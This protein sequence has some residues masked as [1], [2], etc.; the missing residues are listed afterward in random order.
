M[1]YFPLEKARPAQVTALEFIQNAVIKGYHDIVI[2][3]PTGCHAADEQVLMADGSLRAVQNV[4]VGDALLGPDSQPR[5]VLSLCRGKDEMFAV[6]PVKGEPF[7]VNQHHVL[8]LQRTNDGWGKAYSF[9]DIDLK[10]YTAQSH[11]FKHLHKLCKPS[12]VDF[13]AK[14]L[15]IP[16]Y[17]LG[18]WL[19]DGDSAGVALTS[20][21]APIQKEWL[22]FG[23]S[24]Y[25][26]PC[27]RE[28]NGCQHIHL[29][30]GKGGNDRVNG[31]L[32]ILRYYNLVLNKHIPF[33]YLTSSLEDRFQLLAGLLDTD[34][35]LANGCFDFVSTRKILSEQTAYIARSLGFCAT[36]R[37]CVKFCQT[38]NSSQAWR[39][40]ISGYTEAIPTRIHR[41][42]AKPRQQIKSV[43]R[44]GFTLVR[45]GIA[46]YYG[47]QV[48]A[49]H[50]YL[51][52]DFTV[53]HN[54]GKSAIGAAA[55][56]WAG[57]FEI[58]GHSP[59]GYYLVTQ[60][61]LQDQL[62]HDFPRWKP[63]LRTNGGSLKS[64]SEYPCDHYITC[65]A[66]GMASQ[67]KKG[68]K[69]SQRLDKS[70]PYL[71]A[72]ARF[73]L[74]DVAVTNYPYLFTEHLYVGEM[75]PRNF[76]VLDECHT[77]ERQITGFIEILVNKESLDA[78][79]PGCR[80]VPMMQHSEDLVDWL[81]DKYL[82]MCKERLDMLTENLVECHYSNR[83][84]QN[85]FNQ[86]KNHV[87]RIS[88]AMND[89]EKN[90]DDWVFWQEK[91]DSEWACMA[92][93]LSA[94]PFRPMLLND[95]GAIRL[96][97]S[98]YPGPKDVFC[99]SLGLNPKETAWLELDSTFPIENRLIHMTT[100][101]SM[102]RRF[103]EETTPHL[104][105]MCETILEAHPDEKGLIHSH[106]YQ[107]GIK[108]Y[109]YL[110]SRPVGKRV[111][112][113]TKASERAVL[114][115]R[116]RTS[117]YPT[118]MLSPS[119]A[120]GFSFDDDLARFQIIAKVPYPY[121]GD[122]Q[123]AAKMKLDQDWY[124][125]Q[126]VMTVLQTCGRI[127][128]CLDYET[129]ILTTE[130]WKGHSEL[131]PGDCTYGINPQAFSKK[132][133]P[134]RWNRVPLLLNPVLGVTF[135]GEQPTV[136][137]KAKGVDTVVTEGHTIVYQPVIVRSYA[138]TKRYKIRSAGLSKA[139][140]SELPARFKLPLAGYVNGKTIRR[141]SK[142]PSEWFWLMGFVIADGYLSATKNLVIITQ[143]SHKTEQVAQLERVLNKLSLSFTK[144]SH[145][146]PGNP[147]TVDGEHI[148]FRNGTGHYWQLTGFSSARLRD[149]FHRGRQR[150]YSKKLKFRKRSHR[151]VDGW[152]NP[153]KTIPRWCI[154]KAS[155]TQLL[156][157]LDGLMAG[158]GSWVTEKSGCYYSSNQVLIDRVQEI[159]AITG[160]RSHV[161]HRRGQH[162]IQI[163]KI[164][165][166][167]VPKANVQNYKCVPVWCP[168]TALGTVVAR[169]N[170]HTFITGNSDTDHG[171][172][173][174][175]DSDFIR[176][177]HDNSSF[178]PKWFKDGFKF[179]DL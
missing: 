41:K 94:A 137:I 36:L 76:L 5:Y 131:K 62:E 13:P 115:N 134:L 104:L 49:D 86:L 66:G 129:E 149:V 32:D 48:S 142:L 26:K 155:A 126:T 95:M 16:P 93:P 80:P 50:L 74:A 28:K 43:L 84:M 3:A 100:V 85:E 44:T 70:C 144:G 118:V 171:S 107:L 8:R 79:A 24:F 91:I 164:G 121:L 58:T 35:S 1:D 18:L 101:G 39:V 109:D 170:G 159:T 46:D 165:T 68:E 56:L 108:I 88:Y 71:L 38:G 172:T 98:A 173:Y 163:S 29:A 42:M 119:I 87:G 72:K 154:Q 136:R 54:C 112:F 176:L 133:R 89:L 53:H 25:L 113:A 135:F 111:L 167:D 78:W 140:A 128:R 152:K 178:F 69:C 64:S 160:Y 99:R 97:M 110:R 12:S 20:A 179:Y 125:L 21:D 147:M 2:A 45:D 150:R 67:S 33:V 4:R 52:S 47:F 103:L 138:G 146:D 40:C 157:L 153:E 116:H 75:P 34:G 65:M 6:K 77:L 63:H 175:L 7:R 168:T 114:F 145:H 27:I 123:V 122:R 23:K 9:V 10:T 106:S 141:R 61:M 22:N 162:E 102:S 14:E 105:A 55:A 51:G 132:G 82:T 158:D 31:V 156:A 124:T 120:E 127:V 19:G 81:R 151:G 73:G 143:S 15:L 161:R 37:E 166:V 57:S 174:I 60:K 96:F 83:K 11:T 59:G 169:R 130:G 92:K 90:P 30:Y 17:I 177:Y 139:K 117:S 148:Y